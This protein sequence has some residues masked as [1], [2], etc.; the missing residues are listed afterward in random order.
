MALHWNWNDKCGE[1]VLVQEE[2][3]FVISLYEGNAYLIFLR[4]Y[5]EDGNDMYEMF[6]FWVDKTHARKCLGLAKGHDN[7]YYGDFTR[8]RLNKAKCRKAVEIAGL[9]AKAYDNITIEI[10]TEKENVL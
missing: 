7:I 1:V 8:L 10:Y 3:E 9:F 6:S 4:E 2:R 5:N